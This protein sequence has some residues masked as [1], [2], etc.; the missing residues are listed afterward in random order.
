MK[1]GFDMRRW[2]ELNPSLSDNSGE[3]AFQSYGAY[4]T[5]VPAR[6][7][8]SASRPVSSRPAAAWRTRRNSAS[9]IATR[10][11]SFKF[12]PNLTLIYGLG[13]TIDTPVI[14]IAY[15][16]HGQLAFVLA[17]SPRFSRRSSRYRVF[18]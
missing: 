15:N 4:S 11:M 9:I 10:R 5:G 3:F 8:F 17:S 1:F 16:G 18:G 7:F 13:W 6:T 12:R 2:E 14:N